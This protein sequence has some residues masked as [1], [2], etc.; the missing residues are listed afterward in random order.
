MG[1]RGHNVNISAVTALTRNPLVL[2]GGAVAAGVGTAG[3]ALDINDRVGAV[4]QLDRGAILGGGLAL[5]AGGA[6]MVATRG[7]P[8]TGMLGAAGPMT[9]AVGA[10]A[11]GAGVLNEVFCAYAH[12]P[13][14]G[15]TS[16]GSSEHE[17]EGGLAGAPVIRLLQVGG[18]DGGDAHS[19]NETHGTDH[20]HAGGSHTEGGTGHD[21]VDHGNRD[22]GNHDRGDHGAAQR[23]PAKPHGREDAGHGGDEVGGGHT[24]HGSGR[25][26]PGH[27]IIE[28][29]DAPDPARAEQMLDVVLEAFG[30]YEMPFER[31]PDGRP[32]THRPIPED[33]LQE[34]R[35]QHPDMPVPKS[36]VYHEGTGRPVGLLYTTETEQPPALPMGTAH[37]HRE[38]GK[39]MQHIWLIPPGSMNED[40]RVEVAFSDVTARGKMQ[41]VRAQGRE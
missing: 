34:F 40:R 7:R 16:E 8:V 27:E 29:N 24:D 28:Y 26:G 22:H 38:G 9:A 32:R 18:G 13:G 10:G 35:E 31:Q 11:L 6:T 41:A 19:D 33:K 14:S 25:A 4:K 37:Q 36:L 2:V 23:G 20:E 3:F 12:A 17:H 30:D 15:S 1:L 21:E 39:L 5:A